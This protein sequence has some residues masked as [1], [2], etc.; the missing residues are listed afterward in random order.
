MQVT[1]AS[2]ERVHEAT[3]GALVGEVAGVT[4]FP[5]QLQHS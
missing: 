2:V 5:Q 1:R 3:L 4:Q